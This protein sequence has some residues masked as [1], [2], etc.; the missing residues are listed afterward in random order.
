MPIRTQVIKS[1]YQDSVVLMRLAGEV[2]A[3]PGVREAAAF[4]G[5]PANHVLLEQIG[6]ASEASRTARPDDL[7]LVVD[8]TTDAEAEVALAAARDRLAARRQEV[9]QTA[10]GRPRTLASALRILPRANLAAISVPG[11]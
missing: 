1:S 11:A 6:L 4:M 5:T 8:A 7:I 10:E 9:A 2:R 3:W